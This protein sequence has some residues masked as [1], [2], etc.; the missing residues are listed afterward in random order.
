M[1]FYFEFAL[2]HYSDNLNMPHLCNLPELELVFYKHRKLRQDM[3]NLAAL[4]K[5]IKMDCYHKILVPLQDQ[6][7]VN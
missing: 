6:L 5:E 2:E 1:K 3:K 7:L 4:W